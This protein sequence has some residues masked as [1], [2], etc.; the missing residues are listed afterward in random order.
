[1]GLVICQVFIDFLVLDL[2]NLMYFL[3][4]R[5]ARCFS[6]LHTDVLVFVA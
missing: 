6:A 1:M 5:N 3:P 4:L 2:F